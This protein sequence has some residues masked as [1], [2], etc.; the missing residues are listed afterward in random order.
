MSPEAIRAL[1]AAGVSAEQLAEAII[2]DM[3]AEIARK[4]SKRESNRER[5]RR[6]RERD[7]MSRDVT[8]VTRDERD[9][10]SLSL[11]LSPQT[12]LSH[13]HPRESITTRARDAEFERFWE[14]YPL[15]VSK[16]SARRAFSKLS[17]TPDVETLIAAVSRHRAS[18]GWS[19]GF[20][21]HAATWLNGERWLDEPDAGGCQSPVGRQ[22][23]NGSRS[24]PASMADILARRRAANGT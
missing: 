24:G 21:P 9:A 10:P 23:T 5:Q 17:G 15:K 1:V 16:K 7:A 11:S 22:F 2:A 13:T 3:A 19:E 6:K 12:P 4:E 20:I 8:T 14:A 18:R